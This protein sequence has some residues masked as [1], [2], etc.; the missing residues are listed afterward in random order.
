[1]P[2]TLSWSSTVLSLLA[3]ITSDSLGEHDGEALLFQAWRK[4][5]Q[6]W[7]EKKGAPQ[8]CN[9]GP[10]SSDWHVQCCILLYTIHITVSMIYCHL[11]FLKILWALNVPLKWVLCIFI[12]CHIF[13][14][15]HRGSI[16]LLTV[17]HNWTFYETFLWYI[18]CIVK[19]FTFI[20]LIV[21]TSIVDSLL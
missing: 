2:L 9:L 13:I 15:S 19:M 20:C 18:Q 14:L 7:G 12:V 16:Y 11:F 5:Y 8:G 3:K 17:L 10:F 6:S 4:L 1:M 21:N